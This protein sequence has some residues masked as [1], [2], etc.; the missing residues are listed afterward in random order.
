MLVED[1]FLEKISS[2]RGSS[3]LDLS[4]S[5]LYYGGVPPNFTRE[6]FVFAFNAYLVNMV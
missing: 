1:E 2:Q 6:R 4:T 5:D 3:A